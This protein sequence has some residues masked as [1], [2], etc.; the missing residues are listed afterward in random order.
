[1]KDHTQSKQEIKY[2]HYFTISTIILKYYD[3]LIPN[4]SDFYFLKT[5]E[6]IF[7]KPNL[8]QCP[9]RIIL[10]LPKTNV[11][12]N[13]NHIPF[14]E[15]WAKLHLHGTTANFLFSKTYY[16]HLICLSTRRKK[17][18]FDLCICFMCLSE[19]FV[20]PIIDPFD[21]KSFWKQLPY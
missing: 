14:L 4:Q 10:D 7:M 21:L 9:Y 19:H 2:I 11:I 20:S 8:Q 15:S 13:I 16:C 17:N 18:E 1:M 5:L 6:Q 3:N 12:K